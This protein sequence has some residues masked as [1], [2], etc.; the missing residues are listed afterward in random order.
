LSLAST[1]FIS[2]SLLDSHDPVPT[3]S[4][5]RSRAESASIPRQRRLRMPSP[6]TVASVQSAPQPTQAAP[7]N[8]P[9][10]ATSEKND[11]TV[12]TSMRAAQRCCCPCFC[13]KMA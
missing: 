4:A 3:M 11:A 12:A 5:L 2:G 10:T 8:K 9:I 1:A 7:C 6:T 13:P